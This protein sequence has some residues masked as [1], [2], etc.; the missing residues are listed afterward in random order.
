MSL[1]G[2]QI[3]VTRAPHQA[4]ELADLLREQDAVPILYPCIDIA[5]PDDTAPLD[6]ALRNLHAYEWLILTSTNTVLALQQRIAVLGLTIDRTRLKVAA[7][8]PKTAQAASD[9]LGMQVDEMPQD[10]RAES[11]ASVMSV[12]EMMKVLLPQSDRARDTLGNIL[13]NVGADV[14]QV[15][16]YQNIIGHGGADVPTKLERGEIDALTFTS[17]STVENFLKRVAPHDPKNLW[18]ACIGPIT[19]ETAREHGFEQIVMPETYTLEQM[20]KTLTA[21]LN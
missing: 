4:D 14:T 7:V 5:P 3:V 17:S 18:A 2:K 1:A 12:R 19:A 16:A 15:T 9:L 6:A 13:S 11:L 20:V 8:G 10:Y 21:V